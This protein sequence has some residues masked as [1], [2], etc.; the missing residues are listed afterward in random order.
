M[1]EVTRGFIAR[2]GVDLAKRV[3]QVHAV[4][5][6]GRVVVAKALSRDG[7]MPWCAQLP[8]GTLIAMEACSGAHHW[9]RKLR[10]LG[11][12]ARMMA[13]HFV[14]PYRMQGKGGKNDANDAA[15]V[16]EAAS[17][18]SMRFV[19][20]KTPAQQAMLA[21]HRLREGYKEERNACINRIRGLLTEFGLVFAQRPE[22]LRRELSDVLEDATSE[23]PALLRMALRQ[24]HLHWL[25]LECHMAWCDERIEA[26]VRTDEQAKAAAQ[27][28]G[29]GPVTASALVAMVGDFKQF[30]SGNQFGAWLGLVPRQNSSG[31]KNSLGQITKRGDGYLRTL[32][33]QGAKAAMVHAKKRSDR[34]S[35]WMV[36]LI[37]RIGWQKAV[38]AMANKN[39]RILW[40]VLTKGTAY[41]PNHVSINPGLPA[42][43]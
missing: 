38:V 15:A 2:V 24:A 11:L 36:S 3:I 43:A 20:L 41:D 12:D 14:T 8:P 9:T 35:L 29:V 39:A 6:A 32:L 22:V 23:L 28:C 13:P 37:D 5:A 33:I 10:A 40:A 18:P 26:H 16:C 19:P 21:I 17:R 27:L 31:G 4:D 25:E 30:R 42:T 34:I 1:S 7:F